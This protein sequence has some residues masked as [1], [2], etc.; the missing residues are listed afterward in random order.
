MGV[1]SGT[2]EYTGTSIIKKDGTHGG[3]SMNL[4][5]G[6]VVLLGVVILGLA[7]WLD[8]QGEGESRITV[9]DAWAR[10]VPEA[11]GTA[12]VYLEIENGGE[13]GDVLRVAQTPVAA[14]A[15]I[16]ASRMD[17]DIMRMRRLDSLEIDAGKRA[18]FAP[19][20]LHIMLI[21][22]TRALE[23]D[24]HFP[25]TLVFDEAGRVTTQVT[26]REEGGAGGRQR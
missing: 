17:G 23:P 21:G 9:A 5:L 4:R 12:A 10:P 1:K 2:W 3:K 8:R 14:K 18:E 25:L 24:T 7:F 20:G 26:V 16:H 13:A 11:G 19:G 22:L 6:A 15:E